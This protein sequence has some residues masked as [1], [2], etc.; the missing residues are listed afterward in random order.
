M[1]NQ[2]PTKPGAWPAYR[3]AER[4]WPGAVGYAAIGAVVV[5]VST[6]LLPPTYRAQ[7]TVLVHHHVERVIEDPS[8]DEAAAYIDRETVVLET[9]AYSDEV[10]QDVARQM[11][12]KGWMPSAAEIERLQD[13]VRLPH[14]KDGEWR[15]TA[16]TEDP[17][18][19]T[20]LAQAW[21]EAFVAHA[22]RAVGNSLR[23]QWL[24]ERSRQEVRAL[25]DTRKRCAELGTTI[26]QLESLLEGLRAADPGEQALPVQGL[27]LTQLAGQVGVDASA[28]TAETVGDQVLLAEAVLG[29]AQASLQ[30]CVEQVEELEALLEGYE[31]EAD[32]LTVEALT[33][34]PLLEVHLMRQ[35]E[36]PAA[37]VSN[38][39]MAWGIGAIVGLCGWVTRMVLFSREG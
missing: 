15:F 6:L 13:R 32:R 19:S 35:A 25:S 10:W 16:T 36:V 34:S 8:S 30:S 28:L 3:A 39:G 37:P 17:A 7:A 27:L 23:L 26:A 4:R 29:V 2:L 1:A 22:N 9:L 24:S 31:E 5:W 12:N 18:L 20:E 38:P 14:P 21:A 11:V 33:L